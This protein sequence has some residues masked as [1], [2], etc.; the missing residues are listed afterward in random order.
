MTPTIICFDCFPAWGGGEV[1]LIGRMRALEAAGFRVGLACPQESPYLTTRRP[2]GITVY[3]IDIAGT[4]TNWSGRPQFSRVAVDYPVL[5]RALRRLCKETDACMVHAVGSRSAKAS[6]LAMMLG[7]I[8]LTWSAGNLYTPTMLDRLLLRYSAAVFCPSEA[9]RQ[10]YRGMVTDFSRMHFLP[11]TVDLDIFTSADPAA[12][13]RELG[14]GEEDILVGVVGRISPPKGQLEFTE[15]ILPLMQEFPHLH[16]VIVG[17]SEEQDAWYLANLLQ[18]VENSE[19][20]SRVHLPG[21]RKDIPSIMKALD[22]FVLPSHGEG[23]GIVLVEAMAS[24]KP[25]VANRVGAVPEIVLDGISGILID[26]GD[27]IG[28]TRAI[29]EL[30]LNP[31]KRE[32][33]GGAGRARAVELY[34]RRKVHPRFVEVISGIVSRHAKR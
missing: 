34:D 15:S 1:E 13:R 29:R 23:F 25:V 31:V 27:K 19:V 9:I 3:G 26:D 16:A 21:Q 14:L 17:S 30:C 22:V 32:T 28:M 33:M 12:F 24:G 7:R 5:T 10:Q 8:P 4:I 20:R 18:V 2:E 11:N 6:L